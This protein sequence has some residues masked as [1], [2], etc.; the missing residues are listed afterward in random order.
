MDFHQTWC[1]DIVALWFGFA[2]GKILSYLMELSA[3]DTLIFS[4]PDDKLT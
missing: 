4:L 3:R 1:I 2:N